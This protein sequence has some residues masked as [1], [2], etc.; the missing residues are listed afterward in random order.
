MHMRLG[1]DFAQEPN[2][3]TEPAGSA[4]FKLIDKDRQEL[5]EVRA[6]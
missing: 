2:S 3:K 4:S 1:N 6:R 5:Q